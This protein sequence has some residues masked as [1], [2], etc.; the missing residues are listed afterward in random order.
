[1]KEAPQTGS[2]PPQAVFSPAGTASPAMLLLLSLPCPAA[3]T[4]AARS[5]RSLPAAAAAP[6]A[7][8]AASSGRA[9]RAPLAR[10]SAALC[11][12]AGA[13]HGPELL[14][15]GH[16]AASRGCREPGLAAARP[17]TLVSE[18]HR[19]RQAHRHTGTDSALPATA[20]RERN[21]IAPCPNSHPFTCSGVLLVCLSYIYL[22]T[23]EERCSPSCLP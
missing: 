15:R 19:A 7:A 1:M 23:G 2:C 10:S 11:W 8:G 6:S 18:R 16:R 22:H 21:H 5:V 12:P 9:G 20:G 14:R 13:G 17:G 3:G 4:I